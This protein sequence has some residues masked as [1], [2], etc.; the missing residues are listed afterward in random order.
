M[1]NSDRKKYPIALKQYSFR[2]V[3]HHL[4]DI[5]FDVLEME[6]SQEIL[7]L[8]PPTI[9]LPTKDSFVHKNCYCNLKKYFSKNIF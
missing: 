5:G 3:A 1:T 8:F 4:Y 2:Q 6:Y 7:E 9:V